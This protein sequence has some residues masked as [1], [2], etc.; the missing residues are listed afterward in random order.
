MVDDQAFKASWIK[1]AGTT[2]IQQ[3]V[4]GT[5]S[6]TNLQPS[7]LPLCT[8]SVLPLTHVCGQLVLP[9][10]PP[11][12]NFCSYCCCRRR[13]GG[14][15]S[16]VLVLPRLRLLVLVFC[17]HEEAPTGMDGRVHTLNPLLLLFLWQ[18]ACRIMLRLRPVLHFI[19]TTLF[20]INI[21]EYA[22]TKRTMPPNMNNSYTVFL[23]ISGWSSFPP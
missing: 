18:W 14:E 13:W 1:R 16:D 21:G 12:R 23:Q 9:P 20:R 19:S 8:T 15:A 22:K 17:S 10:L 6:L 5:L 2:T 3:R 4:K 11:A 7:R